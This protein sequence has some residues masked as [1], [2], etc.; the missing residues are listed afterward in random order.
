MLSHDVWYCT[1]V[2]WSDL[3][4][5]CLARARGV[6]A[7]AEPPAAR[8]QTDK[9]DSYMAGYAASVRQRQP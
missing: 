8:T 1:N 6:Q 3:G 2:V 4:S 5:L 7:A 9:E